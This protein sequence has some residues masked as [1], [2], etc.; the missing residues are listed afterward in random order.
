MVKRQTVVSEGGPKNS[1]YLPVDD[2]IK[3]VAASM[4]RK[5]NRL[6]H[7]KQHKEVQDFG[8]AVSGGAITV[9]V[10]VSRY[11]AKKKKMLV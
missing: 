1:A 10:K 5:I 2:G 6:C 7:V 9:D 8:S 11:K 3:G 4:G